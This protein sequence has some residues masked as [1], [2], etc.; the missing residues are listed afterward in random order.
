MGVRGFRTNSLVHSYETLV[1][2]KMVAIKRIQAAGKP[3]QNRKKWEND[4]DAILR[5]F[6][7]QYRPVADCWLKVSEHLCTLKKLRNPKQCRE[8]WFNQLDP[9]IRK[10]N[11][12]AEEN[13]RIIAMQ[14]KFGNKWSLIAQ[15][16]VGRTDNSVKNHWHCGLQKKTEDIKRDPLTHPTY[17][18]IRRQL[19]EGNPK[20]M[21]LI[22]AKGKKSLANSSAGG[23][24]VGAAKGK[25]S[26]AK[27]K[28]PTMTT[29][30]RAKAASALS[31]QS[32]A[33]S[34]AKRRGK[35]RKLPI[36]NGAK[37]KA[38]TKTGAI[39]KVALK[40]GANKKTPATA[41]AVRKLPT[42]RGIQTKIGK[43]SAQSKT[44]RKKA[45]GRPQNMR[46]ITIQ[47]TEEKKG[48]WT[49]SQNSPFSKGSGKRK[50]QPAVQGRKGKGKVAKG[51]E[52]AT[53]P[54]AK[55]RKRAKV[56]KANSTVSKK[57][58][59]N[60][61]K[62]SKSSNTKKKGYE[63]IDPYRRSPSPIFYSDLMESNIHNMNL[64]EYPTDGV[65]DFLP[66]S[67]SAYSSRQTPTPTRRLLDFTNGGRD[68][69][70]INGIESWDSV[71]NLLT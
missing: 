29:T 68:S 70:P 55:K 33:G 37:K 69:T 23:K 28:A 52:K 27:G 6:V 45:S 13:C 35:N 34:N 57:S 19:L 14:E 32:T 26:M 21:N 40:D 2:P 18:E 50:R 43:S 15:V 46:N 20:I 7:A 58:A 53:K 49:P 9:S 41:G 59:A 4:E 42:K 47:T 54:P 56:C 63:Q 24:K 8:R 51:K 61:N 11:W 3:K 65:M 60:G 71:A 16:L 62:K 12:S 17:L 48:H 1:M 31:R 36:K 10:G 30:K 67:G 44:V 5:R 64:G 22:N 38:P 25:A 39:K 66:I